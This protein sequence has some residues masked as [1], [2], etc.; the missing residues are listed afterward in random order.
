VYSLSQIPLNP[1]FSKGEIALFPSLEK[2]GQGRFLTL[3]NAFVLVTKKSNSPK[4]GK[5]SHKDARL[6]KKGI[7]HWV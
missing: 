4:M 7:D 5:I 6:A 2:R 1:P 3:I